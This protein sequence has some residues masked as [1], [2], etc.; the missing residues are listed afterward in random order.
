MKKKAVIDACHKWLGNSDAT[1]KAI[2]SELD[3]L[4]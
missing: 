1:T 2:Q 3:K 4:R